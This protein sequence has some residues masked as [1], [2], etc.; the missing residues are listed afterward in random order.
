MTETWYKTNSTD[1]GYNLNN[2]TVET[3]QPNT[4]FEPYSI[5]TIWS[6]ILTNCDDIFID[7]TSV[8]SNEFVFMSKNSNQ[9]EKLIHTWNCST[10]ETADY[11]DWE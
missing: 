6:K 10:E 11:I 9:L 3:T 1:G 4:N 7:S 5:P 8:N 2:P